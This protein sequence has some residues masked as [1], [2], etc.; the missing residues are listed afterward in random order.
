MDY[1]GGTTGDRDSEDGR[2]LSLVN[3][4]PSLSAPARKPS[5]SSSRVHTPPLA[6][7]GFLSGDGA[8]QSTPK[9]LHDGMY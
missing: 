8:S 6:S 5:S 9:R 1:L 3:R 4:R 2:P 7:P